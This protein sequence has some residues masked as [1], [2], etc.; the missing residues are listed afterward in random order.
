MLFRWIYTALHAWI[1]EGD[2]KAGGSRFFG[3]VK[4]TGGWILVVELKSLSLEF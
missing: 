3:I 2:R 4:R 1:E